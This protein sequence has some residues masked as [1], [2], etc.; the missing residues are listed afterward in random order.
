MLGVV[1]G[2]RIELS[3]HSPRSADSLSA[4]EHGV[5]IMNRSRAAR[6][7]LSIL[8][9]VLV[10]MGAYFTASRDIELW[11]RVPGSDETWESSLVDVRAVGLVL[12]TVGL[13]VTATILIFEAYVVPTRR[14]PAPHPDADEG[15]GGVSSTTS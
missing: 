11:T 8:A 14:S 12:L 5:H 1:E 13:V 9:I 2:I 6:W 7:G 15:T 10:G 3:R 4:D